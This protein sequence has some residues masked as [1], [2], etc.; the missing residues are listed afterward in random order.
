MKHTPQLAGYCFFWPWFPARPS[1][2]HTCE[3]RCIMSTLLDASAVA[4]K[5]RRSRSWF[6]E[7]RVQLEKRGFP[8][9]LPVVERW[10]AKAGD[11]WIRGGGG[12]AKAVRAYRLTMPE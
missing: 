9:P 10:D 6:Y 5:L 3:R 2:T 7:H 1:R 4:E 12:M 8:A 11:A